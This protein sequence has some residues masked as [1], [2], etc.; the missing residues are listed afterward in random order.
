MP[1]Q[2]NHGFEAG[3]FL[4]DPAVF[5]R[6]VQKVCGSLPGALPEYA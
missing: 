3:V 5:L 6:T 2:R 1:E 4:E